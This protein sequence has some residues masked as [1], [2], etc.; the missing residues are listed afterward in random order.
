MAHSP[1]AALGSLLSDDTRAELLTVLMDGRVHTGG[2]L[3]RYLGVSPSTVSE[4][5]SKLLDAGMVTV[6]A[7]ARHRYFQL[8]GP[9]IAQLLETLGAT[10]TVQLPAPPRAPAALAYARTCYDHLAGELAVQICTQLIANGHLIETD[11]QLQLTAS[12]TQHLENIGVDIDTAKT[13]RRPTVRKC[14]DW[15]ERR[16][17]LAGAAGAALLHTFLERRW[18]TH[19][20]QPRSIRVTQTGKTA[21]A[22][23]F[24]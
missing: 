6:E 4:H 18:V 8:A 22:E 2:E 19:G 3:A 10:T 24:G 15:T 12:G 11:H 14:L 7:Q 20:Q 17:H 5:L 9:E 1:L 21:I 13:S 23:H 16:P